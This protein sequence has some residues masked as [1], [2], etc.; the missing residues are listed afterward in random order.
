MIRRTFSSL[1]W[2]L[3][4]VILALLLVI[5][6]AFAW[7][8][9]RHMR[10][11][12]ETHGTQRLRA[13]AQEMAELLGQAAA[14][15]LADGRRLAAEPAIQRFVQ[16]GETP[17]AAEA[18]LRA[19]TD[20]SASAGTRVWLTARGGAT[21]VKLQSG[22]VSI[23]RSPDLPGVPA[24][25][26]ASISPLQGQRGKVYYRTQVPIVSRDAGAQA[27]S[28]TL[29]VERTL[30]SSLTAIGLIQRL[31]GND[32]QIKLGNADGSVWTDLSAPVAAPPTALGGA[33]SVSF[34]NDQG[35]RRLGA[36]V[37]VAGAPWQVW[38]DFDEAVLL[39]PA[40][41]A[42]W[43]MLPATVILITIG[44]FACHAI[45]RRVTRPLIRVADAADTIAAGDYSARLEPAAYDEVARLSSAFNVMASRVAE[46][47]EALE[48]RVAERTRDLELARGEL[49][50]FFSMSLD[51]L[52]IADTQ[53]QFTRV[54]PAWEEILGW[55]AEEL[56]GA[57]YITFVHP[58]DVGVTATET[59]KLAAG[60]VTVNFENRYRCKD[61]SYRW[62]SWKAAA[63]PERNRVYAAARDITDARRAAR[64]IQEHATHLAAMNRELEA[65]SYSVSHDL[66]APLR[67]I[68][69]F[70]QALLEDS[71]DR[72]GADGA[73]HL[74]RIR[75]AAQ[76][77]GRLIDDLL[78]L[79]RVTRADLQKVDVDLSDMAARILDDL[80]A[81]QPSRQVEYRVQPG[82]RATGDAR[83]LHVVLTNLLENAW[84]FTSK[85]THAMIEFGV[86]RNGQGP[87]YSVRDNGAGFDMA[88]VG[89]LFGT[90]Q[91]LHHASDFP[92]T[93]VGLATVQR[94][95]TRHGGRIWAQ[96]SPGE[97]A[98]FSFTLGSETA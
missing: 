15:R 77:M 51:L 33:D 42:L 78:K 25:A 9:H 16:T 31:V 23:E 98:V 27:S 21:P 81:G 62:L 38:I 52:C 47:R 37:A 46:S 82:V 97:S 4:L 87:V 29:V 79:A 90:F 19:F 80:A 2:R 53:G 71:G 36:A 45:S 17:E 72:L 32:A 26:A 3:P 84:K 8:A 20:R 1:H 59:Q 64:E 66:R 44:A 6:G 69:G 49:D 96:G 60:G 74:A 68:D 73:D 91:R 11:A 86:S 14:A 24:A 5:G 92:G 58:D 89:K 41:T 65:F 67:S 50:Q 75:A 30:T 7:T 63:R 94:I 54:N 10:R 34:A 28:G 61:G 76:H 55:S 18:V 70:S 83:L 93:G 48:R 22:A 56:T 88:Y 57:P 85:R 35:T 12:L 95:I 13:A 39:E 43:M 40:G